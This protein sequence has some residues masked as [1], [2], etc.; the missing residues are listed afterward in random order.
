VV[1]R[2]ID[3]GARSKKEGFDI[4]DMPVSD[5]KMKLFY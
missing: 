2:G 4:L 5:C 1:I 3:V